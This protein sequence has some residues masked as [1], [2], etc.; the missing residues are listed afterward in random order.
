MMVSGGGREEKSPWSPAVA[1]EH[2]SFATLYRNA[3][4]EPGLEFE[5][6]DPLA[7]PPGEILGGGDARLDHLFREALGEDGAGEAY[8][9]GIDGHLLRSPGFEPGDGQRLGARY[10]L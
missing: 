3:R 4:L 7:V 8:D 9:G 6:A 2:R 10:P 5:F 1:T